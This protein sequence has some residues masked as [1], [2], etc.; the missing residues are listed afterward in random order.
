[1]HGSGTGA[2]SSGFNLWWDES[3]VNFWNTRFN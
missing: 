2:P 1:M 3:N